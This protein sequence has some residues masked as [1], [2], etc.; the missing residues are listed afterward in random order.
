MTTRIRFHFHQL[1]STT[2]VRSLFGFKLREAERRGRHEGIKP[3]TMEWKSLSVICCELGSIRGTRP[4]NRA[5]LPGCESRLLYFRPVFCSL[6]SLMSHRAAPQQREPAFAVTPPW[7]QYLWNNSIM[8][9][10]LKNE[11]Q[12][13]LLCVFFFYLV[14]TLNTCVCKA[15]VA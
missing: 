5:V 3:T 1:H 7:I 10:R 2:S 13:S 15:A 4:W 8:A 6:A 12:H 9:D 11:T 14:E